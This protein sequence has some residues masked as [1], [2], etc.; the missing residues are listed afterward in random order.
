MEIDNCTLP[1]K[2]VII[3]VQLTVT[4]SY[5]FSVK[6]KWIDNI[7]NTIIHIFTVTLDKNT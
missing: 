3:I 2:P 4:C 6:Q 5:F 1:F 7:I